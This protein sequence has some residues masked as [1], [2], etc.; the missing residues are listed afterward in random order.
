[1]TALIDIP[2]GDF[3]IAR[4]VGLPVAIAA[5]LVLEGRIRQTGVQLPFLRAICEPIP[6]E[7]KTLGI[8]FKETR[9]IVL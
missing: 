9:E 3:S 4:T 2:R 1:M 5:R 7:L 8:S 6:A